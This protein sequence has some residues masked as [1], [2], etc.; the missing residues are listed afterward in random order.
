MT[1]N[2]EPT[3]EL[4][5][6]NFENADTNRGTATHRLRCLHDL[7]SD[8]GATC[9]EYLHVQEQCWLKRTSKR[10]KLFA[11]TALRRPRKNIVVLVGDISLAG[12]PTKL[13]KLC[14]LHPRVEALHYKWAS[15]RCETV[16]GVKKEMTIDLSGFS[17]QPL[18]FVLGVGWN[19][20]AGVPLHRSIAWTKYLTRIDI[21][22]SRRCT[23]LT[24]IYGAAL[25]KDLPKLTT[26]QIAYSSCIKLGQIQRFCSGV[27]QV[28]LDARWSHTN[29]RP[30]EDTLSHLQRWESLYSLVIKDTVYRNV[31]YPQVDYGYLQTLTQ[32][33]P[34]TLKHFNFAVRGRIVPE[35]AHRVNE[36]LEETTKSLVAKFPSPNIVLNSHL[37]LEM[38]GSS[39]VAFE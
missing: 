24:L 25:V 20:H 36:L 7:S 39:F 4:C 13:Q 16:R 37:E 32:R 34:N 11:S 27:P 1:A 5:T 35:D 14:C 17:H 2:R 31:G 8:T 38:K 6:E 33:L 28:Y 23:N 26:L 19:S 21:D 22:I 15:T 10:F 30:K 12:V 9:F 3:A 29:H 18:K